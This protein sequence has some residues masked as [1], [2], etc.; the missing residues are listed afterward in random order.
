MIEIRQTAVFSKW[1]KDLRDAKAKAKIAGRIER[2]AMGLAGDVK[3]VGNGLSELR[4]HDGPGYRIYFITKGH[5]LIV[6]LCGGDKS[7][8]DKDIKRAK[9]LA[10]QLE[11]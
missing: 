11:T 10:Q 5:V 4:I 2:L 8:Q 7:S 6:L 9:D 3:P 1:I